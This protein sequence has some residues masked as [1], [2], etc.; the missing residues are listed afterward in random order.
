MATKNQLEK[1]PEKHVDLSLRIFNLIIGRVLKR[2]Y[3]DFDEKID[4]NIKEILNDGKNAKLAKNYML[5]FKKVFDEEAIKIG[6]E[7]KD[8][9][10]S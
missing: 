8:E 10:E 9:I 7:I 3:L 6:K 4:E 2:V 1:I 5:D